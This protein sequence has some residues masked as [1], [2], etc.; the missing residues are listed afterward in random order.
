MVVPLAT[1]RIYRSSAG[2]GKTHTLVSEYLK[3]A[4]DNPE[5]FSQILAV[6]FTNQATQE[7]KQRIL[8][9]LH[10]LVQGSHSPV[11]EALLQDKGWDMPIL[12]ERAQVLLSN[13]LHQYEIG[14]AHV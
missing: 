4:L 1:L 14:R 7:M 12:Q 11:A 8:M 9:C 3:L 10:S 13:I 6:T 2:A 5:A